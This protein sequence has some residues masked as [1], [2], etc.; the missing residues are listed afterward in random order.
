MWLRSFARQIITQNIQICHKKLF[1]VIFDSCQLSKHIYQLSI[2]ET[3]F[4]NKINI[5]CFYEAWKLYKCGLVFSRMVK[6]CH[7][8]SNSA[9]CMLFCI[10]SLQYTYEKIVFW[11][12]K[13]HYQCMNYICRNKSKFCAYHTRSY[14]NKE[15]QHIVHSRQF[16]SPDEKM[17]ISF[18]FRGI[19]TPLQHMRLYT[20]IEL[21]LFALVFQ[22]N[23]ANN[24]KIWYGRIS[25]KIIKEQF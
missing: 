6:V 25:N 10:T 12:Q 18:N 20:Q 22:Q 1:F 8:K 9:F 14:Q 3:V 13:M 16:F 15:F 11:L 23:K 17:T 24:N 2:Q 4:I 7:K 5:T 19:F 21:L